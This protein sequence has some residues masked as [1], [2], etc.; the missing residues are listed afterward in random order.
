MVNLQSIPLGGATEAKSSEESAITAMLVPAQLKFSKSYWRLTFPTLL[1][2]FI[3]SDCDKKKFS[4][5]L[6]LEGYLEIWY[7]QTLRNAVFSA[8]NSRS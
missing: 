3:P 2:E 5:V 1:E 4:I 8:R 6:S 7:T